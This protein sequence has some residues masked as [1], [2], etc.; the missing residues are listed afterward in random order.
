MS[1]YTGDVQFKASKVL[2]E[3]GIMAEQ[4]ILGI[5]PTISLLLS[6][7]QHSMIRVVRIPIRGHLDFLIYG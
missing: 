7:K 6:P 2:H 1:H 4:L 3:N 5:W